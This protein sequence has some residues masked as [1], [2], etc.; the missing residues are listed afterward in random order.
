M[1]VEK[2]NAMI[3]KLEN[4]RKDAEAVDT[5][6][7]KAAATRVRVAALAVAKELKELRKDVTDALSAE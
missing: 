4:V 5:K 1:I 7:T 2:L 3:E 6:K